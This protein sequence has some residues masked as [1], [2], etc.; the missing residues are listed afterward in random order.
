[1]RAQSPTD[2]SEFLDRIAPLVADEARSNLP[3]GIARTIMSRPDVYPDYRL[4]LVEDADIPKAACLI[5]PPQNVILVD[6]TDDTA[7]HCL[8]EAVNGD[9][10]G[11]PGAVGNRPTIDRFVR[12]WYEVSR[13]AAR[14]EMKQGV[15]SLSAVD[16]VPPP[17]GAPRV[18]T[19]ADSDLVVQWVSEFACEAIPWEHNPVGRIVRAV[20]RKLSG[21][22]ESGYWLWERDGAPVS[23]SGY[24]SPTG[25]GIR[26]GPVYT[27]ADLRG[28]GYATGLVASQSKWLI[29]IGY[30]FCFLYTDLANPTSNSIYERIGYEQVAESAQYT[31]HR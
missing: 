18:A 9:G 2:P 5:T 25:T 13:E 17:M 3:I 7:L 10:V 30:R 29:D 24:A 22:H 23:M 8:A 27:P 26:V 19:P 4:F 16:E 1:M 21:Q 6:A 12:S 31:F 14:I 11:V 15:F 20:K 28:N